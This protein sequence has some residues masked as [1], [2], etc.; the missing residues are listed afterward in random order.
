MRYLFRIFNSQNKPAA[1]MVADR[2]DPIILA[3]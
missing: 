1:E 3:L 2:P